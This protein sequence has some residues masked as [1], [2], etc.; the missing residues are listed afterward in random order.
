MS[1][2]SHSSVSNEI[3]HAFLC[4]S[5]PMDI[6]LVKC[7]RHVVCVCVCRPVMDSSIT[8][9]LHNTNSLE[10]GW[11]HFL[12]LLSLTRILH[13]P[14]IT[15]F[16]SV[17]VKAILSVL[18][19]VWG[20]AKDSSGPSTINA[21]HSTL[22]RFPTVKTS[23]FSSIHHQKETACWVRKDT[24]IDSAMSSAFAPDHVF[25]ETT[26]DVFMLQFMWRSPLTVEPTIIRPLHR[27]VCSANS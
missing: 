9:T 15:V 26:L 10:I 20:I 8:A 21:C 22:R 14:L 3:E 18:L 17:A 1:P 13:Q 24:G 12:S 2:D 7:R 16:L 27:R 25:C 11:M 23:L 5:L 4:H 19:L 6:S